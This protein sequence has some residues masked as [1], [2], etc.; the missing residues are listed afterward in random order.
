ML[1]G[2]LIALHWVTFFHA[3]KISNISITL[4]CL[5]SGSLFGALFEPI[6]FKRKLRL[7]EVVL[8]LVV[9]VG[10]STIFAVETQYAWGIATALT[11]ASLSALFSTI[12]G[13]WV[14]NHKPTVISTYEL[15]GGFLMLTVWLL[16]RGDLSVGQAMNISGSDWGYLF[17]LGT[18]CTAYPFIEAVRVMKH[19]NPFTVLLTINLEPVYGI[20]LAY[21]I[22]GEKE[23]MSPAF[24]FGTLL[25]LCAVMANGV[26]E[27]YRRR[28]ISRRKAQDS[29]T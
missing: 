12:N 11:S 20:V 24:Y 2:F 9:I 14:R 29:A 28:A 25:I 17:V 7:Y 22:F 8:G 19:L 27:R 10:I 5:S 15:T 6:F 23:Q 3:I 16:I 4:A 21:L 13:L 1:T 26:I 18:I